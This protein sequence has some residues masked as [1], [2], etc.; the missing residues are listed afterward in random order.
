MIG[1]AFIILILFLEL[2]CSYA[3]SQQKESERQCLIWG[4]NGHPLSQR[5]YSVQTLTYQ[6]KYLKDLKVNSYRID[7]RLNDK[8]LANNARFIPLVKTLRENKIS[9]LPVILFDH[10]LKDTLKQDTYDTNFQRGKNFCEKYDKYFSTVE[11][12]NEEETQIILSSAF[13]G[14]KESHYDPEKTKLLMIC[15][16]GFTDGIKSVNPSKKII[17]SLGWIHFNYLHQLQ[18]YDIKFDIIG[19]HWYSNMGDITIHK[20]YG[21]IINYVYK[22]FRKPI[23]ITEFNYRNGS[24]NRQHLKQKSYLEN[25][26][27][28]ILNNKH[29]KG[30]FIYELFDEPALKPRKPTEIAYGLLKKNSLS[31]DYSKKEA[32]YTYK[33]IIEKYR[34]NN[35]C[36]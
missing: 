5:D 12:G 23:W 11:V 9:V 28:N 13:D 16:K 32:Y 31:G 3:Y 29:V 30:F 36:Y 20:N 10:N 25:S 7:I 17:L 18:N 22:K 19:Y 14:T 8:G 1:K 27:I 33:R 26:L 2:S 24:L 21:N 15:L 35:N 4:I 34:L 6:I